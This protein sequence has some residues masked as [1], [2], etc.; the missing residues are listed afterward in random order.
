MPTLPTRD[1]ALGAIRLWA[2]N[3]L[4]ASRLVP[5]RYR[6][7]L[8]RAVGLDVKGLVD[9]GMV[10]GSGLSIGLGTYV[11]DR[12]YFDGTAPVTLGDDCLVGMQ[13]AFVTSTHD[14]EGPGS[15]GSARG[16]PIE[17]GDRCWIGAR[18]VILPGVRV[19]SDVVVAAGSVVTHSIDRP[20]IYAGVPAAFVRPVE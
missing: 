11:N 16:E 4:I 20:G 12:C 2:A 8:Y 9:F 3:C 13:A 6:G 17:V 10:C 15:Y 14:I 19:C 1:Q 18:A 5:R 7:R